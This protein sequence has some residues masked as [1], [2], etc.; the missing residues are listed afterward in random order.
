MLYKSQSAAQEGENV[1]DSPR[2]RLPADHLQYMGSTKIV[3]TYLSI[4]SKSLNDKMFQVGTW[5]QI[6]DFWSFFQQVISRCT[7]ETLFGSDIFKRYPNVVRD[8]W[9]FSDAAGDFLPGMPRYMVTTA[10]TTAREQLQ[11]GLENWLR[12]NHSGS[13]FARVGEEDPSWD[14][15]K[16]SKFVQQ[17]DNMLSKIE[18]ID[19]EARTADLLNIMHR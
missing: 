13:D 1:P 3:E 9:K 12:V 18:G 7:I 8:L 5:T 6:E 10:A 2:V 4:L 15:Y 16:G 19:V 17:R 11:Q 14:E